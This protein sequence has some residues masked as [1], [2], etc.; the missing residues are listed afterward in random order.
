M[1]VTGSIGEKNK[2]ERKHTAKMNQK[3]TVSGTMDLERVF[4]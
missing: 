1:A 2:P 3:N 4:L